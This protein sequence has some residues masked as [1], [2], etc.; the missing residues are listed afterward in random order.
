MAITS[1]ITWHA[2]VDEDPKKIGRYIVA[3][4]AGIMASG[5]YPGKGWT[6]DVSAFTHWAKEPCA[7]DDGTPKPR[8]AV[9]RARMED[10]IEY[11]AWKALT[12]TNAERG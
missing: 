3:H 6:K 5:F 8:S 9:G 2:I 7:P 11:E 10:R 12:L 1:A 4:R